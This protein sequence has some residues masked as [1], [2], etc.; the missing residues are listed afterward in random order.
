MTD[1][2]QA[3]AHDLATDFA[4][5]VQPPGD[6]QHGQMNPQMAA[7][8]TLAQDMGALEQ[9]EGS[10]EFAGPTAP[11]RLSHRC[12]ERGNP[13]RRF[14]RGGRDGF[15]RYS[16]SLEDAEIA[17]KREQERE[18]KKDQKARSTSIASRQRRVD[19]PS[20]RWP[21]GFAGLLCLGWVHGI[22]FPRVRSLISSA[23]AAR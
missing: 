8:V 13:G 7:E 4:L 10:S 2:D 15:H 21:R 9:H 17:E 5:V 14:Q 1:W 11:P 3:Q 19:P 18:G 20:W 6:A 23:A 16:D 12:V 22:G